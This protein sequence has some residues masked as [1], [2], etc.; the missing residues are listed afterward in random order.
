MSRSILAS[1]KSLRNFATSAS[2]SGTERD[3]GAATALQPLA[4]RTQFD[5]VPLGIDSRFAASRSESP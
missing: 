5:S 3:P 2:S 4:S 1:A